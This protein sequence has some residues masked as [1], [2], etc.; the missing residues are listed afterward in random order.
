MRA[1]RLLA[2]AMLLGAC[3]GRVEG[4]EGAGI[5]AGNGSTVS[6]DRGGELC[7]APAF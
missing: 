4:G 3:T 2:L 1:F 7:A 5:H 6:G